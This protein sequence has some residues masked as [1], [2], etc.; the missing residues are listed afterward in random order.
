M[1]LA[2]SN[3]EKHR[4]RHPEVVEYHEDLMSALREPTV[5]VETTDGDRHYYRLGLGRGK[6]Q[7][8]YLR[9]IVNVMDGWI[10]TAYFTRTIDP[11]GQVVFA[12]TT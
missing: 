5:V 9:V 6:F 8:T 10:R 12:R 3:W 1:R 2:H 4:P 7:R 11:Y